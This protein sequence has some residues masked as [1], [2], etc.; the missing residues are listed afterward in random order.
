MPM[1][2]PL[3]DCFPARENLQHKL[4]ASS[5]CLAVR[6]TAMGGFALGILPLIPPVRPHT[7]R[8]QAGTPRWRLVRAR[9]ALLG[10]RSAPLIGGDQ[11]TPFGRER[12]PNRLLSADLA[13][14]LHQSFKVFRNVC[15]WSCMFA[16]IVPT[17]NS[18]GTVVQPG[19]G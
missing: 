17:K 11:P 14:S 8:R 6:M 15:T 18:S 1:V 7:T 4:P 19:D 10:Y 5:A 3:I 9:A 2:A 12:R 16:I 13:R